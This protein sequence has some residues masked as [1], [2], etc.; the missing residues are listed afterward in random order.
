MP[1]PSTAPP[2]AACRSSRPRRGSRVSKGPGDGGKSGV[3][4]S[5]QSRFELATP[6]QRDDGL[7]N[8]SAQLRRSAPRSAGGVRTPA[9]RRP[10]A[11]RDHRSRAR[12]G[13][14]PL[15]GE[16]DEGIAPVQNRREVGREIDDAVAARDV[17]E[18]VGEDCRQLVLR[19]V[20][21]GGRQ[22]DHGPKQTGG[23]RR[24]HLFADAEDRRV[25]TRSRTRRHDSRSR[26]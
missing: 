12:L 24:R 15:D 21:R 16:S 18:L 7:R 13:L 10:T 14:E 26:R 4:H 8:R 9:A 20:H 11:R 5:V 25:R 17:P 22:Q 1:H 6:R 3:E 23:R 19:R 2:R